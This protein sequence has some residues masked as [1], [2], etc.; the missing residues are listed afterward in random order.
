MC[1]TALRCEV[2]GGLI[3]IRDEKRDG[4]YWLVDIEPTDL[5]G[6][7]RVLCYLY[8]PN[9]DRSLRTMITLM[10]E[11]LQATDASRSDITTMELPNMDRSLRTTITLM[12]EFLQTTGAS[13]SDITTMELPNISTIL[14]PSCSEL[15]SGIAIGVVITLILFFLFF[16]FWYLNK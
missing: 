3:S 16:L 6:A 13:R 8:S 11:F 12:A 4:E 7:D 15:G 10:A 2:G 14:T 9:M 5:R 1:K